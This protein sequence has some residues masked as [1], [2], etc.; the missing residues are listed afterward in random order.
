LSKD[1][2]SERECPVNPE[3]VEG[4]CGAYEPINNMKQISFSDFQKLDLRVGEIKVV[5]E[6]EGYDK[7]SLLTVDLGEGETC[8]LVAGIKQFYKLEE[9]TGRQVIVVANLE[10]KKIAG[11][12]SQGMLLAADLDGRPVLIMPCDKVPAGTKV[13]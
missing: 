7:L 13:R 12:E 10:P 2:F 4:F 1:E 3:F 11:V 5:E 6:I 8:N 9:I